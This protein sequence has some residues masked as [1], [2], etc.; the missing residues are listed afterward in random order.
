MA[1]N[2]AL[3]RVARIGLPARLRAFSVLCRGLRADCSRLALGCGH[4]ARGGLP[5][6]RLLGDGVNRSDRPKITG[7]ISILQIA[8]RRV[9]VPMVLDRTPPLDQPPRVPAD[10]SL[11]VI[12]I[13]N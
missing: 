11:A 1:C 8:V 7:Q 5:S 12:V 2:D 4:R 13:P 3:C 10:V 6:T 9:K